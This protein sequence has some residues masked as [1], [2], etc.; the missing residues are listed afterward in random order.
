LHSP[1]K[2]RLTPQ[3][4]ERKRQK[5]LRFAEAYGATFTIRDSEKLP[6][7][8]E[9]EARYLDFKVAYPAVER[10]R[11]MKPY[12]DTFAGEV[13]RK[14]QVCRQ[15]ARDERQLTTLSN[16]YGLDVTEETFRKLRETRSEASQTLL[17]F[18]LDNQDQAMTHAEDVVKALGS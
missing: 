3:E 8:R 2:C 15:V 11:L 10:V 14:R 12:D 16:K 9:L 1:T 7:M 4:A 17:L 5:N 13:R 18:L 6:L